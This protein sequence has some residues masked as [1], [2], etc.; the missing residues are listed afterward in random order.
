M[1]SFTKDAS[2]ETRGGDDEHT[3]SLAYGDVGV[4][5]GNKCHSLKKAFPI[6]DS[7]FK[8]SLRHWYLF[9]PFFNFIL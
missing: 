5:G 3:N 9:F 6:L 8:L 7:L 4:N 2:V 1:V